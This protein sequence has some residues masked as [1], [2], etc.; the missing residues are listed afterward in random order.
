MFSFLPA[1]PRGGDDRSGNPACPP[2]SFPHLRG[3]VIAAFAQG[4]PEQ[5]P[6]PPSRPIPETK[7]FLSGHAVEPEPSR[8]QR[9]DKSRKQQFCLQRRWNGGHDQ[10]GKHSQC[11]VAKHQPRRPSGLDTSGAKDHRQQPFHDESA[12]HDRRGDRPVRPPGDQECGTG[13]PGA[14]QGHRQAHRRGLAMHPH[15]RRTAPPI[16]RRSFG[17]GSRF[18]PRR[19]SPVKARPFAN[20]RSRHGVGQ[21]VTALPP[22]SQGMSLSRKRMLHQPF[23]QTDRRKARA[24]GRAFSSLRPQED[25][26]KTPAPF[27]GC[28]GFLRSP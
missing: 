23:S 26:R 4:A 3:P 13:R 15:E 7:D 12:Q 1:C 10:F 2:V 5:R 18:N 28:R 25:P 27:T 16:R 11:V 6:A 19:I 9:D 21:P 14:L 17:A 20:E 22:A 24:D 8:L